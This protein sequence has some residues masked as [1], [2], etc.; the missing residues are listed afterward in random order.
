MVGCVAHYLKHGLV[1]YEHVNVAHRRLKQQTCPDFAQWAVGFIEQG[2][3]Y[4]KDALWR[5][6]REAYEPDYEDLSK[7]KFGYWLSDFARIHEL[8][9]DERRPR[10]GG[11]RVPYITF[12]PNNR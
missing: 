12:R 5:T 8:D 4:E 6:F 10:Q 1:E 3:E 7:R 2:R 11:Q 9:K